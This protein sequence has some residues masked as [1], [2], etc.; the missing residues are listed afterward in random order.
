MRIASRRLHREIVVHG[1]GESLLARE[2]ESARFP[3]RWHYHPESEL[4]VIERGRGLRFVGDSI[5]EFSAGDCCLIGPDCPHS[6][7]SADEGERGVRALVVQFDCAPLAAALSALPELRAVAQLLAR[8]HGGLA[9]TGRTAQRTAGLVRTLVAAPAGS[10][11]RLLGLLA[12]LAAIAEGGEVAGLSAVVRPVDAAAQRR[13]GSLFTLLQSIAGGIS[14]RAAARHLGITPEAFS[15][16]FHRTVG[17]TFTAYR[18]DLRISGACQQLLGSERTVA[19]IAQG[20][21]FAN[22]SNFNRRF[23]AAKGMTPRAFR[24]LGSA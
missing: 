17:R 22:L 3:F 14:Q 10:P 11:A 8:A 15:R 7:R 24:R 5:Q 19:A 9:V 16:M 21:G 23:K 1:A 6:W 20:S 13:L 4:T 2:L 18:N 12:A